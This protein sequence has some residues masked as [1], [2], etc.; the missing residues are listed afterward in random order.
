MAS[1]RH[2]VVR[3]QSAR[4]ALLLPDLHGGGAERVMLILAREF[5]AAGVTTELL[6]ARAQG[7][8]LQTVPEGLRVIDLSA[9]RGTRTRLALG[10]RALANLTRYLRREAPDAML[11]TLTGT[12][13]I[14]VLARRLAG[15]RTRLVLREANTE[16]NL[17]GPLLRWASHRL[18][19]HADALVG[20]SA[21]IRA[22]LA[23]KAHSPDAAW[24]IPNPIDLSQ[25][26]AQAAQPPA[27]AWATNGTGPLVVA[28]GRLVAQKDFA[29][30]LR[31]FAL[32]RRDRVDCRLLVLGDGPL[33]AALEALAAEL[34]ITA[35]VALTGYV[36]NPYP[37]LR[38]ASL[39]V[40]SSRWEGMPN[41]L[42]E[43]L[44]LGVPVVSTDCHSGPRQ[45]LDEGRYGRLVP[46]G[47]APALA[48]AMLATLNDGAGPARFDAAAYDPR[49]IS[50]RY[51]GVLLPA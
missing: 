17:R 46:V 44:A 33:R 49:R 20:V 23:A 22:E 37:I 50:E 30:L 3:K 40:L 48:T 4:I 21:A 29:T 42:L 51:L 36:P 1:Q 11:S 6:L 7:E 19:R 24:H 32:V 41:A 26:E 35:A 31:A 9:G 27:H 10:G 5:A 2:V 12:N 14:A 25:L 18:Y 28:I 34:N 16:I 13:L 43:A 45:I 39:F 38:A 47:D 8:L 15:T